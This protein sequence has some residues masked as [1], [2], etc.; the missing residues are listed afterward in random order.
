MIFNMVGGGG[1]KKLSYPVY[2][3]QIAIAD[4]NPATRVSYPETIFDQPNGAYEI[5]TPASGTGA[6]CLN[7]WE[8]CNLIS[9]IHRQLGNS[10]DGWTDIPNT[11]PWQAGSGS[12]DMMTYFPTWYMKMTND[13]TYITVGFCQTNID[14]T[15][16]DYAGSVGTERIGHFR[17]GCFCG[18]TSSSK[19]YSLG[20]KI[21]TTLSLTNAI[22]YTQTNRGAGY[23]IMTWYQWTY[24]SALAVLL[25]KST[26]LQTALGQGY[27]DGSGSQSQT[28]LPYANEYGMYGSTDSGTVQMSFFWIQNLWG[29]SWHWCGGA[30]TD[31]SYRLET[32]TGYSS[33]S[34]WDKT[35]LSPSRSSSLTGGAINTVVGTTDAGFFPTG[36]SG[37]YTTYFADFGY[38]RASYFPLV[39]GRGLD[40]T[41]CGPFY[42]SFNSDASYTTAVRP[43]YRL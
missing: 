4:S 11:D 12:L 30:H 3:F 39:G 22:T 28:S 15:W 27:V 10:T 29:N 19:L 37:S 24:L 14:G 1:Q 40:G 8:G 16:M 25:Y 13:G 32:N 5:E 41:C 36:T 18:N 2:G 31:S 9:G 38:V 23:D 20:N 7:D 42:A 6:H 17:L 21:P 33:T 43:S 26:D 34:S 35:A